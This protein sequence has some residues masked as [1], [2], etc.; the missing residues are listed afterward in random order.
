MLLDPVGTMGDIPVYEPAFGFAFSLVV[1]ARAGASGARVGLSTFNEGSPPDLQIQVTRPL[2]DGSAEVCDDTPPL[3]GGVPATNPPSFVDTPQNADRLNDLG[4]RF[5]DGSGNR[6][7]RQC[8]DNTACVLGTDGTFG[9]VSARASV[10]F[11]GFIAQIL[12]FQTGETLV[13]VRVRDVRGNLGPAKQLLV[14]LR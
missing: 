11:C 2:G 9:C 10:Q 3:L 1:E 13:T 6:I 5:I 8:G 7:G 4:C 14:R 12:S